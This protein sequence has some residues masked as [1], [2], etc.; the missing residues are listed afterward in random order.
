MPCLIAVL[1]FEMLL[2]FLEFR[3]MRLI[4]VTMLIGLFN[5][6]ASHSQ[7]MSYKPFREDYNISILDVF[8]S[9][10][11]GDQFSDF[12]V[13]YGDRDQQKPAPVRC[14]I[15]NKEEIF[16]DLSDKCFPGVK[17]FHARNVIEANLNNNTVQNH[18][19]IADHGP[20]VAPFTG[21]VSLV[22]QKKANSASYLNLTK[23]FL[24]GLKKL[25]TYSVANEDINNDYFEDLYFATYTN[26]APF[27]RMMINQKNSSFKEDN[28]A[29]PLVN[30]DFN[31]CFMSTHFVDL[32]NDRIKELVLGGC[33]INEAGAFSKTDLIL[34]KNNLGKY[35]I[36][37][38]AFPLRHKESFWGTNAL[39]FADINKDGL[40]DIIASIH[41]FKSTSGEVKV[42]INQNKL[43]FREIATPLKLGAVSPQSFYIQRVTTTDLNKDGLADLFFTLRDNNRRSGKLNNCVFVMLNTGKESFENVSDQLPIERRCYAAVDTL[44]NPNVD[45]LEM[46]FFDFDGTLSSIRVPE[47]TIPKMIKKKIN[48]K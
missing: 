34:K 32:D 12:V 35:E 45:L 30:P 39:S 33:N 9:D 10:L 2:I 16:F 40:L 8:K 15:S 13:L 29:F 31:K 6:S 42:Y 38:N 18:L 20:D 43:K 21:G 48:K 22:L 23:E 27:F 5:S 37:K 4:F 28:S 41:N 17:T 19:V 44:R 47:L 1:N 11:N 7:V 24:P 46:I 36:V 14:L 25:F 26:K 3:E